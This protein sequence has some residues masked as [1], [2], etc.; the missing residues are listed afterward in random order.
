MPESGARQ[1]LSCSW[2]GLSTRAHVDADLEPSGATAAR[3]P[4]AATVASV[5]MR[6]IFMVGISGLVR[7][8]AVSV[9]RRAVRVVCA[10]DAWCVTAV[11][12]GD[13]AEARHGPSV[14]IEHRQVVPHLGHGAALTRLASAG[15]TP[16]LP[17]FP[18]L[19]RQSA[20]WTL[21]A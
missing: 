8:D 4:A 2:F 16:A 19:S 17:A 5:A 11:T 6:A 7:G 13:A 12:R 1:A 21:P 9:R 20:R 18:G 15:R 14:P 10:R 3:V